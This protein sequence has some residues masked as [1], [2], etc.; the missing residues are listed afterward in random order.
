M[1][2][3]F[4]HDGG[5][6]S[7]KKKKVERQGNKFTREEVLYAVRRCNGI[8]TRV[9]GI[10]NC[11]W[12]TARTYIYKWKTTKDLFESYKQYITDI[13]EDKLKERI[14]NGEW[15]AIRFWLTTIG[16]DRGYREEEHA[17]QKEKLDILLDQ[18]SEKKIKEIFQGDKYLEPPEPIE[19]IKEAEVVNSEDDNN[20]E[21]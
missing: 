7:K 16:K 14:K 5:C 13:A 20:D 17:E 15:K 11:D 10:L 6:L 3:E 4:P 8:V 12:K 2:S 1:Y 18:N 9:A 21:E 19:D